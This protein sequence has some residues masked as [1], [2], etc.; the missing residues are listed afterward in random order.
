MPAKASQPSPIVCPPT[1]GTGGGVRPRSAR[2]VAT[3][4]S[5]QAPA[6]PLPTDPKIRAEI[7]AGIERGMADVRAGRGVDFEDLLAE[8][9]AKLAS[10][11]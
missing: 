10:G 8:W 5:T 7:L 9:D 6:V 3:A 1:D 4:L 11:A 2:P